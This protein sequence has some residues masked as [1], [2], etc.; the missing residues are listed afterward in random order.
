LV[1][2]RLLFY[3][4]LKPAPI[5][6]PRL[7]NK[8]SPI[9]DF[10]SPRNTALH[11]PPASS[12]RK[13]LR[14]S[15]LFLFPRRSFTCCVLFF[16]PYP[17]PF[18]RVLLSPPLHINS[19]LIETV[20]TIFQGRPASLDWRIVRVPFPLPPPRL[21]LSH[22]ED[23]L[24]QALAGDGLFLNYDPKNILQPPSTPIFARTDTLVSGR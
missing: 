1:S 4:A 23:A 13:F 6:P 9:F 15:E 8:C 20:R 5:D 7:F 22:V 19:L 11:H 3:R 12:S 10:G 2:P 16:R 14:I 17:P 24:G 18:S 21:V